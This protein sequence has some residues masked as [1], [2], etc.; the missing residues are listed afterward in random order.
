[1]LQ[2]IGPIPDLN[3]ST[4]SQRDL[5]YSLTLD[6][7]QPQSTQSW[8][9]SICINCNSVLCAKRV[10]TAGGPGAQF[11]LNSTL[12]T[13]FDEIVQRRS[14]KSFSDTFRIL[15]IDHPQNEDTPTTPP[16]NFSI[17]S[18]KSNMNTTPDTKQQ[19]LR[20][21]QQYLQQRQ[22]LEIAETDERIRRY[23]EQQFALLKSFREKSE[24]EYDL[25]ARLI[26]RVSEQQAYEWL[27]RA[28]PAL[29]ITVGG[30]N[31]ASIRRN[32]IGSRR[33][34]NVT[35]PTTPTT[36]NPPIS[37][38]SAL[39]TTAQA[40]NTKT[41][42][43]ET[44]NQQGSATVV[45]AGTMTTVGAVGAPQFPTV[46]KMSNFDTPPATPEAMPMSVGNSPTFR[47]QQQQPLL[48]PLGRLSNSHSFQQQFPTPTADVTDDCFFE[49][50]GFDNNISEST[51]GYNHL[52]YFSNNPPQ[53]P[54]LQHQLPFQ[55][56]LSIHHDH[57]MSDLK[58]SDSAEEAEDALDLDSSMPIPMSNGDRQD[59]S[60]LLNFGKSL[61]IEISNAVRIE[62]SYIQESDDDELD[63][64]VD[65]AASI[66]ALAKSV[67]G[68]AVFGD[69][70]RPRL[71]SQI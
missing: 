46:R 18:L 1:F 63:N 14:D 40:S 42:A 21:L 24:Q 22:K 59:N 37:N 32:T 49:L 35:A 7:P 44:N 53:H 69:L 48:L 41:S 36:P 57:H 13:N 19:R 64:T 20:Q 47:P 17:G 50:E 6:I 71:R 10:Q 70:P 68:E 33:E 3:I 29:D 11:L 8:Q 51:N 60:N 31:Y 58:E 9:I 52:S 12:L 61:P 30:V 23:T 28:P 4:I 27:D 25:L 65:I 15:I 54:A 67:H 56:S 5:I 38:I 26:Q 45:M 66:K 55:R 39:S 43:I 2:S 34:L 16:I 62:R